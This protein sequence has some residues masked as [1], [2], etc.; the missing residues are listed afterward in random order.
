MKTCSISSTT[1]RIFYFKEVH[2][3]SLESLQT[4]Q[5]THWMP[6]TTPKYS[7]FTIYQS[8]MESYLQSYASTTT[9]KSLEVVKLRRT[10]TPRI[11]WYCSTSFIAWQ[12]SM[13]T[14]EPSAMVTILHLSMETWSNRRFLNSV[15]RS[16]ATLS[17][18]LSHSTQARSSLTLWSPLATETSTGQSWTEY[19]ILEIHLERSET[20]KNVFRSLS[21]RFLTLSKN[22]INICNPYLQ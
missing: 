11:V 6:G 20:G 14:L 18:S 1:D 17:P 9:S 5:C 15:E 8:L 7:T 3:S 10:K 2:S 16:S 4:N 13:Q 12:E 21:K 19:T 22:E